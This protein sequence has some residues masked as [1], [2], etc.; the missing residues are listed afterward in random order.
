MPQTPDQRRLRRKIVDAAHP[1]A[2]GGIYTYSG[3]TSKVISPLSMASGDR[4]RLD[5][6][7]GT[8]SKTAKF[9]WERE[10]S[11]MAGYPQGNSIIGAPASGNERKKAEEYKGVAKFLEFLGK[12]EQQAWCMP[13]R[14]S[15]ASKSRWRLQKTTIF[16]RTRHV[17]RLQPDHERQ[18]TANSQGIRWETSMPYA[19]A[20][21]PS[22]KTCSGKE[23][24]QAGARRCSQGRGQDPQGV[25]LAVQVV[26]Q[27]NQDSAQ[28]LHSVPSGAGRLRS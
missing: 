17:D 7:R 6:P 23:D 3:R 14:L 24:T 1:M 12:P 20:S 19:T 13:R 2:E 25:R 21:R 5:G 28:S 11:R 18:D 27:S 9:D 10:P 22:W 26:D 8:L 15:P 4:P 16:R